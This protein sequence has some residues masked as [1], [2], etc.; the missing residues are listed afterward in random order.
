MTQL[1]NGLYP[2]QV[3]GIKFLTQHSFPS[4]P[5]PYETELTAYRPKICIGS[6]SYHS[7][8]QVVREMSCGFELHGFEVG[9]NT[10]FAGGIVPAK[11]YKK[12]GR[13]QAVMIEIRRD[14]YLDESTG[15]LNE[16]STLVQERLKNSLLQWLTLRSK[17]KPPFI[18]SSSDQTSIG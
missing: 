12:D 13:V 14:L 16:G 15:F 3:D 6:D 7:P 5:L 17:I 4:L 11:H 18:D 8:G 10:P 2:Q 1:Q 9:I